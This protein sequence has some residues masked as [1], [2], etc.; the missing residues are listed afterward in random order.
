MNLTTSLNPWVV[1]YVGAC[2]V[3]SGSFNITVVKNMDSKLGWVTKLR[4]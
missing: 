4:L 3:Y 2:S 1:Y